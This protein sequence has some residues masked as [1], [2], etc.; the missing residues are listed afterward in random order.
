[1]NHARGCI[2]KPLRVAD[3]CPGMEAQIYSLVIEDIA[4]EFENAAGE[5]RT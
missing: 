4:E 3:F 1:M 5:Y 2:K